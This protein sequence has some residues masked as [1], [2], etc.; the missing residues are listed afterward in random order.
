[1]HEAAENHR[2]LMHKRLYE[3]IRQHLTVRLVIPP[4]AKTRKTDTD[5]VSKYTGGAKFSDLKNWLANLVVLF[6]AEQYRGADQDREHVLHVPQ[7]LDDE[8]KRWFNRHV[9]HVQ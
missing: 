6:K 4:G 8:A 1:M 5:S 7:F 3:L 9:L 2:N